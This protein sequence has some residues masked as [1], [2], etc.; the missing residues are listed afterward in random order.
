MQN[1]QLILD[2]RYEL[3][4]QIGEGGFS[5]AYLTYDHRLGRSVVAK[6]MRLELSSDP[7]SL[8]R[9]EREAKIAASVSGPNIV[10]IYDY[11]MVN[12]QP[13]IISQLIAGVDLSK[14]IRPGTG[15]RFENAI[16]IMLD[17]LSGLETLH[18][19]GIQHRDI[20]P[21]N[22]LIPKWEAPAKLT[23]F[24]IS[25]GPDDPRLTAPGAVLG[26][27]TY[28]S[29]EQIEGLD[30]TIGTDIY[31]AAVVL[32]ELVTGCPP[33]QGESSSRV[34]LQHLQQKPPAPRS[35]NADIPVPLERVILTGLEKSPSDRYPTAK[36]M[37]DALI[38]VRESTKVSDA[39]YR[40]PD[41]TQYMPPDDQV[42]I[43]SNMPDQRQNLPAESEPVSIKRDSSPRSRKRG[44]QRDRKPF[45]LRNPFGNR[46]VPRRSWFNIRMRQIPHY[47]ILI[48]FILLILVLLL[49]AIQGT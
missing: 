32:F 30:L 2:D 21:Q 33:F 25:R 46:S 6:V 35:L 22:I 14:V 38:S 45:P 5:R 12:G 48:M 27:P 42:T 13:V 23:D 16:D 1:R 47:P 36:S 41:R 40:D 15:L 44:S 19:A 49:A 9:F 28:M 24:G 11:G 37:A 34:M 31:S 8:Q 10:D 17:V 7:A 3:K 29:P 43:V 20:K 18:R 26:S 4:R 39:V